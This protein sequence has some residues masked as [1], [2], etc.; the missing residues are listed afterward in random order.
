MNA[1]EFF[2]NGKSDLVCWVQILMA[3]LKIS[4]Y[5]AIKI[6]GQVTWKNPP[7]EEIRL[8]GYKGE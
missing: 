7:L 1:L 2:S 4:E 6:L 5:E 3:N 8:D